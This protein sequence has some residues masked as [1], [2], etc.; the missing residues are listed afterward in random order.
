MN[1]GSKTD[2]SQ[3]NFLFLLDPVLSFSNGLCGFG[4]KKMGY[5]TYHWS[6]KHQR[7]IRILICLSAKSLPR[8]GAGRGAHSRSG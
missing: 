8:G 7:M 4:V 2:D 6:G 1:G 5:V 3:G